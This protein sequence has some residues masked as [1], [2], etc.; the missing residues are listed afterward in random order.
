MN[1]EFGNFSKKLGK[2]GGIAYENMISYN[3]SKKFYLEDIDSSPEKK[4]KNFN[5]NK[6]L[7][8]NKLKEE[9]I[10]K[11]LPSNEVSNSENIERGKTIAGFLDKLNQFYSYQPYYDKIYDS[12]LKINNKTSIIK[13]SF[14]N[15]S[16]SENKK[17]NL[18]NLESRS[19]K[20][21]SDS[22]SETN[23]ISSGSNIRIKSCS[24]NKGKYIKKKYK[25][26]NEFEFDLFLKNV[27]GFKLLE[28]LNEMNNND[29]LFIY[30]KASQ[31]KIDSY[32]NICCEITVNTNDIMSIKIPQIFK[33]MVCAKFLYEVYDFF[34]KERTKKGSVFSEVSEFF[35]KEVNFINFSNETVF[36]T[37]SNGNINSFKE[38]KNELK[39]GNSL[40]N[41]LIDMFNNLKVKYN[42][43]MI[44]YPNY[45]DKEIYNLYKQEEKI[46]SLTKLVKE[47]QNKINNTQGKKEEIKKDEIKVNNF[48]KESNK[49]IV[50]EK[51]NKNE[52]GKEEE[53]ED[54]EEWEEEEEEEE[55]D[56]I[57]VSNKK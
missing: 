39:T 34:K 57:D 22:S 28:Y 44:Y 29:R 38:L 27:K 1:K 15:S 19:K 16:D 30:D 20:K 42:L 12:V 23:T 45:E 13:L 31:I 47:L 6:S 10:L 49:I 51:I 56:D 50:E 54:E 41:K 8:I 53:G 5:T 3:I 33:N 52:E 36:I 9:I 14:P 35:E 2:L 17:M 32:Y 46:E 7:D 21:K 37:L 26:I 18:S 43:Y 4:N 48:V 40:S 55:E 11:L 24:E 25:N